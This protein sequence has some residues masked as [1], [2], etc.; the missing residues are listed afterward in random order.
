M[1]FI[2]TAVVLILQSNNEKGRRATL[3]CAL[4]APYVA[5][6]VLVALFNYARFGSITEFGQSYQLTLLNPRTYPYGRLS[7]IPKGI[8]AYVFSPRGCSQTFH[9]SFFAKTSSIPS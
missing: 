4:L 8:Y 2:A 6:G 9:I 1:V 5:I 3:L 7:Y